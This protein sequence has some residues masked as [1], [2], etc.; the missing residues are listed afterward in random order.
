MHPLA[1]GKRQ[2]FAHKATQALTQRVVPT[3]DVAGF[4][5]AFVAQAVSSPWKNL[6]V[7]QPEVAARGPAAVVGRDALAQHK[8]TFGGAVAH[9][10]R[11]D[12]VGL[13]AKGDPELA[14]VGF[15]ADE[16]P[17][18]VQFRHIALLRRQK[19]LAQGR[20]DF[21]FFSSQREI[22]CRATPKTRSAA[23]RLKR[24]VATPRSTSF[25][26]SRAVSRLL[27][28]STRQAPH[29]RQRNC[30][31]P[32]TFL[33]FLTIRSLPHAVQRGAASATKEDVRAITKHR[34]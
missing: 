9:E 13:A 18:F 11:H 33:P 16:T 12:L 24:S 25:L 4:A 22:V 10:V 5:F 28:R 1:L 32:Q 8:G 26:R 14:S 7:G 17:E 19:R 23:R 21:G 20:A 30:W 31:C 15:G 29:A 2:G 27:G 6:G 34:R 3:F